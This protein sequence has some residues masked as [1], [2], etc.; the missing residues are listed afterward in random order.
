MQECHCS[1]YLMLCIEAVGLHMSVV[2]AVLLW[3]L[4]S[5]FRLVV[6]QMLQLFV[7]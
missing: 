4:L 2:M 6:L 5:A 1:V 7:S 3:L